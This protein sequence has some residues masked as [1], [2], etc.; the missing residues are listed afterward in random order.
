MCVC[1]CLRE[2]MA[3]SALVRA[4]AHSVE[5]P[6]LHAVAGVDL[7]L[8]VVALLGP[9]DALA[10]V[11]TAG[12]A[13][14]VSL[15]VAGGEGST[16]RGGRVTEPGHVVLGWRRLERPRRRCGYSERGM[17]SRAGMVVVVAVLGVE[18]ASG[19]E[20]ERAL[21][22]LHLVQPSDGA[23]VLDAWRLDSDTVVAVALIAAIK[24]SAQPKAVH[25][26][27]FLLEEVARDI[28]AWDESVDPF[29]GVLSGPASANRVWL[30]ENGACLV[31]ASPHIDPSTVRRRV[32]L[33]CGVGAAGIRGGR[34]E[35]DEES[36]G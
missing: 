24:R 16:V 28:V 10:D 27:T 34:G 9:V 2:G 12:D 23:E 18:I 15:I 20:R 14:R 13:L 3:S 25:T 4:E 7:R 32:L 31:R 35:D 36:G 21:E 33:S 5:P 8:D 22:A 17:S 1:G 6:V 11:D 26:K 30:A 19:I 29:V